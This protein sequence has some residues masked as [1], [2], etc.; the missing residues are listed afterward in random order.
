MGFFWADKRN[1]HP[2]ALALTGRALHWI[3]CAM[4]LS[5]CL[6]GLFRVG[7]FFDLMPASK[8]TGASLTLAVAIVSLVASMV[9]YF[10][11]R[12]LRYIFS[13]E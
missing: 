7:M 11:S 3:G 8:P 6:F 10:V 13:H 9:V 2:N 4:A 12:T 5:L 1:P